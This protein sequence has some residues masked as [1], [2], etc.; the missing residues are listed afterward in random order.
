MR[1]S[2][3][4]PFLRRHAM[5]T[6]ST[7]LGLL[8]IG[9]LVA[10]LRADNANAKAEKGKEVTLKGTLGCGKCTFKDDAGEKICPKCNNVLAVKK[11]D[12]TTYYILKGKGAKEGHS[13]IC[14]EGKTLDATVTGTLV[15]K[16]GKKFIEDATIKVKKSE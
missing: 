12:K 10:G 9:V 7:L 8:V 15:E 2:S 3:C 16:D 14:A 4:V 6:L 11:G 5:K 13:D 1:K